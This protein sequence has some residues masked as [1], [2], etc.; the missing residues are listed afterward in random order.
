MSY[1]DKFKNIKNIIFDFDGVIVDS[2]HIRSEGF[3]EIFCEYDE[4][5][6]K[7]LIVY[8]E[9]NGGLSRF[10][11]IKYFYNEVLNSDISENRIQEYA[12]AFSKIMK[13]KLTSKQILIADT[14]NFIKQNY[15]NYNFHIASGSEEKELQYLCKEL[16]IYKY[17]K[18]INGSPKTKNELVKNIILE[19][20]YCLNDTV[21]IGDSINDY[22]AAVIN[23]IGFF[24]YNNIELKGKGN[25]Y[26]FRF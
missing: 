1:K 20:N 2:M 14:V 11:K 5:L 3:R 9:I 19:N 24:G 17:F 26:I 22:E 23:N 18:T 10:N 25:G 7:K 12:E 13:E 21:L 8:N 6:V 4:Q 16:E 15:S